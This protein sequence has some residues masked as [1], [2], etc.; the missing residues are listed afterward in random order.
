MRV[1]LDSIEVLFGAFEAQAVVR[2]ELGR[3]FG[4]LEG[5]QIT[6]I[7][8]GERA[9]DDA[10]TRHGI[11]EYVSDCVIALDHRV[12]GG[13]A[14]RWLQVVKYRGSTHETNEYPFLISVRGFEVLPVTAVSLDYG[15]SSERLSTGV[16]RLDRMLSGGLYRGSTVL[17]SGAPG[18]GK[19]S[20]GTHLVDAAC[21]RGERAL[22]ILFEESPDEVVRN[23]RSI[24]LDLERWVEAGSLRMWAARPS[25]FGLETWWCCTTPRPRPCRCRWSGLA[26]P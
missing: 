7:V 9:N 11:E 4:W 21:A 5:R 12:H 13:V 17:I 23:M 18:T 19:T 24:G 20:L 16:P 10:L 3:L 14:T 8:T 1:A 26:R 2:A 6:A 25:A 22:L 15:A